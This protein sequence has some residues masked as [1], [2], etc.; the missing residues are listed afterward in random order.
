M[1]SHLAIEAAVRSN[2]IEVYYYFLPDNT[3]AIDFH[4]DGLRVDLDQPQS[5]QARF[6]HERLFSDRLGLTLGPIVKSHGGHSGSRRSA[7]R[8]RKDCIDIRETGNALLLNP[9]ETI[10]IA[11]NERIVLGGDVFALLVPRIT[12]ADAGILLNVAYIDA[13][14]NGTMQM[15]L[16]NSTP[17]PQR[18]NL[19]EPIAQC[20]FFDLEPSASLAF[21]TNFPAKS[22]HYGQNWKKIINEDGDPFPTRKIPAS[23]AGALDGMSQKIRSIWVEHGSKLKILGAALLLLAGVGSWT[24]ITQSLRDVPAL[25]SALQNIKPYFDKDNEFNL[26]HAAENIRALRRDRP[27]SGI[28]AV[29]IP[30]GKTSATQIV[31]VPRSMSSGGTIWAATMD[32][33]LEAQVSA[34]IESTDSEVTR[35]RLTVHSSDSSNEDRIIH[36]KW[37]IVL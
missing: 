13:Y 6:F 20:L 11:T 25:E 26:L 10:S 30:A 18:L 36:V 4:P 15:V 2:R 24:E 33:S 3:G 17:Y 37:L 34:D 35:F 19:I 29:T 22:H 12:L 16:T 5:P 32:G 28:D 21:K 8:G 14:W 7:F 9:Y 23:S 31:S 27:L 1:L